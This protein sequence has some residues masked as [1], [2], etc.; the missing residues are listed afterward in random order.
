MGIF[1]INDVMESELCKIEPQ[2]G[3]ASH[4][5]PL[6]SRVLQR[7][8]LTLAGTLYEFLWNY[9][10]SLCFSIFAIFFF[11]TSRYCV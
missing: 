8:A 10:F 1:T 9:I 2:D 11:T 4:S 7:W 3:P 5:Y 6:T